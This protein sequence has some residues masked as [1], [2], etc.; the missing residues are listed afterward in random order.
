MA[1]GR[2]ACAS[3]LCPSSLFL[4]ASLRHRRPNRTIGD[5]LYL[6]APFL[7]KETV[8]TVLYHKSTGERLSPDTRDK[9]SLRRFGQRNLP[10]HFVFG[11]RRI[12]VAQWPNHTNGPSPVPTDLCSTQE[13]IVSSTFRS[14]SSSNAP[15]RQSGCSRCEFSC[16]SRGV[17]R[18]RIS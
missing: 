16:R 11:S 7:K 6:V 9:K 2:C 13:Q 15:S 17:P 10:H 18:Q 14:P 8:P 1:Q 5:Y 3:S 12:T 4:F